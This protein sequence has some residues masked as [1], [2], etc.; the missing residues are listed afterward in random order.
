MFWETPTLDAESEAHCPV[1]H[2]PL[3]E[4][5]QDVLLQT[6]H[7]RATHAVQH[8]HYVKRCELNKRVNALG[9]SH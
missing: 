3:S 5:Q 1:M 9:A 2:D 6:V 7:A 4:E 8:S